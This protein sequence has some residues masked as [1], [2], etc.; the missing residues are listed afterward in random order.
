MEINKGKEIDFN[1]TENKMDDQKLQEYFHFDED[2]LQANR[3]GNFSEKQKNDILKD[4]K[5]F[6]NR[7]LASLLPLGGRGTPTDLSGDSLQKAEGPA[8]IVR[9]E[10]NGEHGHIHTGVYL[11]IGDKQFAV[12]EDLADG[13]SQGDVYAVYYDYKGSMKKGV[14]RSI[15]GEKEA[16]EIYYDD[17]EG[18]ILSLELISKAP[19]ASK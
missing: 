16:Y 1:G 14:K 15:K 19:N 5:R 9:E 12:D 2:D 11:H 13:M 8:N 6:E 4:K 10:F 17:S 3:N 7:G 18:I